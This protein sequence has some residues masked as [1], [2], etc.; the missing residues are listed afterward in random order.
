MIEPVM[1][2]INMEVVIGAGTA[3]STISAKNV[4]QVRDPIFGLSVKARK[5]F[6]ICTI[7]DQLCQQNVNLC[8][9]IENNFL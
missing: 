3:N 8:A 1:I 5:N 6:H 9:L 7:D 4:G 2:L